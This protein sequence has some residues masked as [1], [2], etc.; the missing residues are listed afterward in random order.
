M[1]KK[2]FKIYGVLILFIAFTIAA[3]YVSIPNEINVVEGRERI[4]KFNLPMM[5]HINLEK[6]GVMIVNNEKVNSDQ[7]KI[8]LDKPFSLQLA[9]NVNSKMDFNLFGIPLKTVRI[10]TI[11]NQK[12][13]P[14]GTVKGIRIFTDGILVLGT[15]YV[16][17]ADGEIHEPTKDILRTGDMI[18]KINEKTILSK[19][20]LIRFLQDNGKNKMKIKINRAGKITYKEVVPVKSAENGEY[21][22]GIWVRDSTQGIGTVTYFNPSSGYYGALGHGILDVDT[23][24]LM[25]VKTGRILQS[26]ITHI[27]KGEKGS[28]GELMGVIIDT[29]SMESGDV[30]RNT[31]YGI[32]GK[33]TDKDVGRLEKLDVGLK[34][35]IK[36][37]KAYIYSDILGNGIEKFEIEI[38]NINL[39]NYEISKGM[40]V[41]ITDK[42]LLETTNGI[43]QGMSGSPIIQNN[44]IIGAV[45]HVFVNEPTKGYAIFIE[46]MLKEE[47]NIT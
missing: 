32:F 4:F 42:R 39:L 25:K 2:I 29:Q 33:M 13:I 19:L 34:E 23:D 43:I 46:N 3:I 31:N 16:N 45:T 15:G 41:K 10:D 35:D 14:L 40:I 27:K 38:Q 36:I 6:K 47:K 8:N 22:I 24:E 37:G 28:P 5:A 30:K 17:G 44:K 12:I 1:S 20:D 18:I 9:N 11:P 7:I 21:K 26:D